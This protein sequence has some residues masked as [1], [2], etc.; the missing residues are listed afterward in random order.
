MEP[1]QG[2]FSD[3]I[4]KI[5]NFIM[6]ALFL[7]VLFCVMFIGNH[8]DYW[9]DA[10]A[11]ILVPNALLT[12]IALAAFGVCLWLVRQGKKIGFSKQMS[13]RLDF[14]L[15]VLFVLFYFFCMWISRETAFDM[16]VDQG[17]VR[18]AA[19]DVAHGVPFGY[20]FVFSMNYN[21]LPITYVLGRLY[22]LAENWT[23]FGHDPEY[24]WMMVGCL[25]VTGAG[26][27]C[28]EIVK[29]LTRN[30]AVVLIAFALYFATA[31]ISPWKTIPYTDS[32]GILFPV[33]CLL[34]YLCS[35]DC[36]HMAG[37]VL[38]L[39]CALFAGVAGG[40]MKPSAYIAVLAVL[41]MEGAGFLSALAEWLKRRK[42]GR[43]EKKTAGGTLRLAGL[44]LLLSLCLVCVFY[45]GTKLCKNYIIE[46]MELVYNEEIEA[47]AQYFFFMGT[48]E[49]TTG[50]FS[51]EDYG[52]FGA[53]QYSKADR[54]AACMEEAWERIRERGPLGTVYFCLRKLVKSFND[55]TFAWTNVLF[56][57]PFPESLIHDNRITGYLRS[58]LM[59]GGANQ[60][61]YDTLAELVWI[62]TLLGVPCAALVKRKKEYY[63]VFTILVIGVLT[64][65]MLFE[66]GARYVY[67]FLPVFIAMSVCGMSA[68]EETLDGRKKGAFLSLFEK[69]KR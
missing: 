49:L 53:Y 10:K 16:S 54:N 47:T 20:Q 43:E 63:M 23:W 52:I 11:D 26:F 50:G 30:A 25:M 21:N 29:K 60:A 4:R 31:G 14:V 3:T 15:V 32:Y 59:P 42:E 36:G 7:P 17:I 61:K 45:G 51:T 8:M 38:L 55:G 1:F 13:R 68:A 62:F 39:F 27:C 41:G 34:L 33:L 19:K 37:K 22:R 57:E 44:S 69:R 46:D 6:L 66:S 56:Y 58:L 18:E 12:L 67:I 9:E 35:K 65:L 2:K 28:C 64:Y 48:K 5:F 40:F 24:L